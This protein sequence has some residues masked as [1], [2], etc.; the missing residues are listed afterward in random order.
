MPS[1]KMPNPKIRCRSIVKDIAAQ[2]VYR[3]RSSRNIDASRCV[4]MARTTP[5]SRP[6]QCHQS[7]KIAIGPHAFC[8]THARVVWR[9]AR[10]EAITYG[11]QDAM[12]LVIAKII[13][14]ANKS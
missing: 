7:P 2:L 9:R 10:E 3:T 1:P 13:E 11:V 12:E 14:D 8:K 5:E 4:A 6:F